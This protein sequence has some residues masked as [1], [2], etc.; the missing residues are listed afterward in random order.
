MAAELI[1]AMPL[2]DKMTR[3]T[4][5]AL[6]HNTGPHQL[7][8]VAGKPVDEARNE[9]AARV[10]A[11]SP[12][13]EVV[14]WIDDDAWWLPG[15]VETLAATLHERPDLAMVAGGFS[16]RI[17][18]STAVARRIA[19][20]TST[21]LKPVP[22]GVAG[23]D[24][25]L[26]DIVDIAE[27]GMHACAVRTSAMQDCGPEPFAL[28]DAGED[29]SFCARLRD[30]GFKIACAPAITFGHI[31]TTTGFAYLPLMPPGK[32][33]NGKARALTPADLRGVP[34]IVRAVPFWKNGRR[35]LRVEQRTEAGRS[36]GA[37]TDAL[38]AKAGAA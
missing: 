20:D 13:P 11:L 23:G 33:E 26:G 29:L 4:E 32:I 25:Y 22:R 10:L 5:L 19:G 34:G 9:L 6:K 15:A 21:E 24:C 36:Y 35:G 1:I 18:H 28:M 27:C 16:R 2:R 30:R 38:R 8:T 3:E 37:T 14:V 31:D 17:P 7:L 12:R